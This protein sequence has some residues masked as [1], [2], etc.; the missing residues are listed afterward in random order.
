MEQLDGDDSGPRTDRRDCVQFVPFLKYRNKPA[1]LASEVLAEVPDQVTRY[2]AM[3]KMT[4]TDPQIVASV[5]AAA[6]AAAAAAVPVSA[7]LSS[8]SAP[9][10]AYI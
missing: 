1:Q 8:A 3:H 7:A 4:P 5:T 9:A 10:A 2:F 6:A